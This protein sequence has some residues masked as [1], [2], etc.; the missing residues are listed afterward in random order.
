VHRETL[1]LWVRQAE[2]DA[3]RS[4][5]R[6]AR[7]APARPGRRHAAR[8]TTD[9]VLD[10][11]GLKPALAVASHGGIVTCARSGC[12]TVVDVIRAR[13]DTRAAGSVGGFLTRQGAVTYGCI[14]AYS[15]A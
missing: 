9:P 8:S 11:G 2:A 10:C 13:R 12:A 7:T 4:A 5:S 15:G 3:G 6:R 14:P 1:R